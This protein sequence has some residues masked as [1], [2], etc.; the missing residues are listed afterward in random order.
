MLLPPRSFY[1][2]PE[3]ALR[4]SVPPFDLVG[5]AT[6]D[7]L[8]LSI[9]LPPVVAEAAETISGL[10]D[11]EG[12]HVFPL[13]RRDSTPT[14]SITIRRVK[15]QGRDFR[16]IID[17]PQGVSIT[18]ADVLVRRTAV[19]GFEARHG[20]IGPGSGDTRRRGGP[21]GPPRHDWDGFYGALARRIHE[22]GIP[23]TQAELVRDMLDWFERRS[24]KEAP[25][26]ST[27]RR[28][29]TAVWK[30]LKRE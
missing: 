26:E 17:P 2:L 22:H 13:F 5:W 6:E 29:I 28:K 7:L 10:V 12:A 9:L 16:W 18:A 3:L 15:P 19:V 23:A 21:G 4:W 14:P 30:E 8:S 24:S 25:D 27:V 1:S 20:M 11:V